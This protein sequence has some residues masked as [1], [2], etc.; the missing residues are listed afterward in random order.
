VRRWLGRVVWGLGALV[1]AVLVGVGCLAGYATWR[2]RQVV[3]LPAPT[4]PYAVGRTMYDWVDTTRTD[5]FSPD[6]QAPRELSVWVWY[7]AA[8]APGA[9]AAAYLPAA[10][11]Q[12]AGTTD[13]LQRILRTPPSRIQAQAVEDAPLATTTA[14]WP[15]LVFAPGLGLDAA[16]YTT[17]IEDLASHGYVVAA[18]NPT[19][20][21][22]VVLSGG[23]V[24][25]SVFSAR[26]GAD[27]AQLAALWADD[28]HFVADQMQ[29]GTGTPFSG[30]LS[31]PEVGFFGH[32]LGGAASAEACSRD[33][34]CPG[35]VD[36]DGDLVGSVV[37]AGIGK[38]FLFLGHEGTLA[39]DPA[40]RTGIAG[41]LRGVPAGD[42]RVLTVTGTGHFSF[43]DRA[44]Y[45]WLFGWVGLGHPS[46]G[47]RALAVTR[48]YVRAFFDTYLLGHPS[49]LMAGPSPA[50]PEVQQQAV[51]TG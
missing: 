19:F 9:R 4:G 23:R 44:A 27:F 41:V 45:F 26:D 16:D 29:S 24:V 35:A 22:D 42:G 32:S 13:G 20:S 21:T 50:Y 48:A 6:G 5:P 34:R 38:P 11:A 28:L 49:P 18:V 51:S 36:L 14:H 10:W 12:A 31:E 8:P 43:S 15:L 46:D 3:V 39:N 1:A 47:A 40:T 33:P 30:H 37:G 17:I 2:S 7:P 25:H